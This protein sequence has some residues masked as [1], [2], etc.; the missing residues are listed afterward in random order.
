MSIEK[1]R[2]EFE[3]WAYHNS[4]VMRTDGEGYYDHQTQTA[5]DGWKASRAVL[6]IQIPDSDFA[7]SWVE[8]IEAVGVKWK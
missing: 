7:E 5:W 2:E 8:A 6:V 4:Y 3:A 1:M